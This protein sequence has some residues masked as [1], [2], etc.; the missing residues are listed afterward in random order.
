MNFS[1]L[2][3]NHNAIGTAVHFTEHKLNEIEEDLRKS[4]SPLD[5]FDFTIIATGSYGRLEASKESD[6]DLFIFC[7]NEQTKEKIE[8]EKEEVK[9]VIERHISKDAGDSGTFGIE[10]I[11]IFSDIL[12][13]IG[14]TQDT[15]KSLTRRMLFLLEGRPIHNKG[16][17]DK[18]KK[19]LLMKYLEST[20]ESAIDKFLLNDII[21]YYRTITTD[22]QYK[23]DED[24][25]SWGIRNIKLRFSRKLLYFAGILSI[26]AINESIANE[27]RVESLS[28]L[29]GTPPLERIVEITETQENDAVN[30]LIDDIFRDYNHFLSIISDSEKRKELEAIQ[31]K[32]QRLDNVLYSELSRESVSFTSNLHKLLESSFNKEHPIHMALIF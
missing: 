23:V 12:K 8:S 16:V 22:F 17:F 7:E 27:S 31:T 15:N 32:P 9:K 2:C 29:F 6:L 13:N 21:R 4:L 14:G 26:S 18:Y 5:G 10:A 1:E 20:R 3:K 11:D 28:A 25:K 19:S 30:T 24:G